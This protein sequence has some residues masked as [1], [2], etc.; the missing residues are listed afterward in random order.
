MAQVGEAAGALVPGIQVFHLAE[1]LLTV[2][3]AN[4]I[5]IPLYK[6]EKITLQIIS[7]DEP[8][9]AHKIP[10][11]INLLLPDAPRV[12]NVLL[13][14]LKLE[15]P[16]L[17]LLAPAVSRLHT[18]RRFGQFAAALFNYFEFEGRFGDSW[19]V[20]AVRQ[21]T[22]LLEPPGL[23]YQFQGFLLVVVGG[24]VAGVERVGGLRVAE[25]RGSFQEGE[26]LAMLGG[27]VGILSYTFVQR[28]Q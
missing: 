13:N 5:T 26:C 20:L 7:V 9:N 1:H 14:L 24:H 23:L 17:P 22:L 8:V 11:A 3:K 16:D 12:L 21:D 2:I 4:Y 10:I 27:V 28:I 6:N 18:G 19:A 15:L 25:L